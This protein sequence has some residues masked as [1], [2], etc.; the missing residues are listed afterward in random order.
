MTTDTPDQKISETRKVQS[1]FTNVKVILQGYH[2]Y[3][4]GVK[5][6]TVILIG[7]R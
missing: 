4:F 3:F 1:S 5:V 2:G 7:G 6:E